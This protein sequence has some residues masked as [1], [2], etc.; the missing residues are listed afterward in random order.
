MRRISLAALILAVAMAACSSVSPVTPE[1]FLSADF[2]SYPDNYQDI[3][4]GYF[5]SRLKDPYTAHYRISHP[6][7]GY[8]RR[9]PI[10]GGGV[11]LYGYVVF[12]W[13]N[14]KN[15]F[16]GYVGEK[17]YTL[18][19]RNGRVWQEIKPNPYFSEPWYE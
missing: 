7:K 11:D 17:R 2:G 15:S 9:A 1:E 10:A 12:V 18:L 3:V 13:V 6:T 4:K 8:V 14:A 5:E 19:V 16:G